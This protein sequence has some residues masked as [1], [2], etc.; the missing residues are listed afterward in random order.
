MTLFW[1]RGHFFFFFAFYTH[2]AAVAAYSFINSLLFA[3]IFDLE[4][5]IY[6]S[7]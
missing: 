1:H 4:R 3:T 2:A 7:S 5:V 6:G